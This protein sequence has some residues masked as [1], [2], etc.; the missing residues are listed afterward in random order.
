MGMP[1][2]VN[3]ILKLTKAQGY[4]NRLEQGS[5]HLGVK[6]GY[7]ILPIDV[8]ILLVDEVW[9][10]QADVVI[11]ELTWKDSSTYLRFRITRIHHIRFMVK[12]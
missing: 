10:A 2:E 7:R 3:S 12:E 5:V 1:C 4:P 8:P 6:R 9:Q 11:Q